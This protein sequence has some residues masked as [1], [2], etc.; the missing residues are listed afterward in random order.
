MLYD[1]LVNNRSRPTFYDGG[2]LDILAYEAS[3]GFNYEKFSR[4]AGYFNYEKTVFIPSHGKKYMRKMWF[5][6]SH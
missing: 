3:L 1:Y 4:F 2:I 6:T 5:A